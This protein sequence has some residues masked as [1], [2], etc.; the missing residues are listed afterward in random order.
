MEASKHLQGD[1]ISGYRC[2]DGSAG[3]GLGC[4][5]STTNLNA[6]AL[7]LR[8]LRLHRYHVSAGT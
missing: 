6:T 7:G 8:V 2:W 1:L 5:S 3:I 4:E